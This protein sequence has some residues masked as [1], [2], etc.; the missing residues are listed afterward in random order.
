MSHYDVGLQSIERGIHLGKLVCYCLR[1]FGYAKPQ[2]S[3]LFML[4]SGPAYDFASQWLRRMNR[5][6]SYFPDV[7]LSTKDE[8]SGSWTVYMEIYCSTKMVGRECSPPCLYSTLIWLS[9]QTKNK[10]ALIYFTLQPNKKIEWLHSAYQ[11]YN[12]IWLHSQ[13]PEWSRSIPFDSPIKHTR[14]L[15]YHR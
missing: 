11:T 6:Y 13:E 15:D 3:I 10:A 9:N 5:L 12:W 14:W 1:W 7:W 2:L 8:C 4:A